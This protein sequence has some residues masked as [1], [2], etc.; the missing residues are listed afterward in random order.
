MSP[1]GLLS[2]I[3]A[4]RSPPP[5]LYATSASAGGPVSAASGPSIMSMRNLLVEDSQPSP[6]PPSEDPSVPFSR[7]LPPLVSTTTTCPSRS[8]PP[9]PTPDDTHS[10]M[11]PPQYYTQF[12]PSLA[13]R[14]SSS[15][16]Y[17]G[18]SRASPMD[19]PLLRRPS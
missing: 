16:E 4:D 8:L 12:A 17:Q 3:V 15:S 1:L 5:L 11:T 14:R 19:H 7:R 10:I 6:Q 18:S 2:P 13:P 9:P